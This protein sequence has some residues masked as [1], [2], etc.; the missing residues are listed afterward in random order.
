MLAD[1]MGLFWIGLTKNGSYEHR[2]SNP[3]EEGVF[4]TNWMPNE[5]NGGDPVSIIVVITN[6]FCFVS[7][8][9]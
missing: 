3:K 8:V 9:L 6:I 4:F 7:I 5:P 1:H 2:W